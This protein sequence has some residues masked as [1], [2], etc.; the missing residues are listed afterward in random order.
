MMQ[1]DLPSKYQDNA[2]VA[3][4][5]GSSSTG[6]STTTTPTPTLT[7]E[8]TVYLTADTDDVLDTL[9]A[10]KYYVIGGIVDRNRLKNATAEKANYFNIPKK[11]L[12]IQEMVARTNTDLGSFSKVL[13]VNQCVDIL[14]EFQKTRDWD[15][16]IAKAMP[17][18][19]TVAGQ[20]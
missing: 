9:D 3:V 11:R 14:V 8:N 12:P 2:A 7:P 19:R 6:S 13:T 20:D 16:A 18:R 17:K 10:D 4:A 5:S 1:R 15:I